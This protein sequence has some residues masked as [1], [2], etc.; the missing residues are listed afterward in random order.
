MIKQFSMTQLVD[1]KMIQHDDNP[2][3][4]IERCMGN[5]RIAFGMKLPK[6]FEE[7]IEI[8]D[9]RDIFAKEFRLHVVVMDPNEYNRLRVAEDQLQRLL[10]EKP[11][12]PEVQGIVIAGSQMQYRRWLQETGRNF[13]EYPYIFDENQLRALRG[14]GRPCFLVGKYLSSDFYTSKL[15]HLIIQRGFV[16]VNERGEKLL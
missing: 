13:N 1:D 7:F 15:D 8:A 9:R 2:Q 6:E 14:E 11:V 3:T 5:I 4:L 10:A 16:L 12:L